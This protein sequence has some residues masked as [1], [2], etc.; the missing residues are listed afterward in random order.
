MSSVFVTQPDR[1][2]RGFGGK[3]YQVPFFLQFV[4]GYCSEVVHSKESNGYKGDNT[5]N[6]IFA[7]PHI[8]DKIFK[9]RALNQFSEENR[10]FPLFRSMDDVP[11][12][13]DPVLLCTIG[14]INYYLGPLNTMNNNPTWNDDPSYRPELSITSKD[15]GKVSKRGERGESFNFNKEVLYSRLQKRRKEELDYGSIINETTGDTL[16]EGRHGN[17]IRIGSRS[18]NPYVFISNERN[19]E[20]TFESMADGTLITITSNGTLRQHFDSFTD[21]ND[22]IIQFELSSDTVENITYPIGDIYSDLNGN[23][24]VNEGIYGYSGNQLLLQSDRITLN[25]R[26]EDIFISSKRD[27]HIGAGR[28]MSISSF[29]SLNLLSSN[30]NIGNPARAVRME[31]MVLGDTLLEILNELVETLNGAASLFYGSPLPL[32]DSTNKPLATTMASLKQK[33]DTILSI[34]HKIEDN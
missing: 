4:P 34:H 14:K 3:Q 32:V 24:D 12:K 16:M 26:L 21:E 30:V 33:L 11:S 6:T 9:R 7:V 31:S 13:G 23:V 5:I 29:D 19:P 28:Y 20:N 27:I 22:N 15:T 2:I 10:Y 18:N 1:T 8:T 25:T 17:S